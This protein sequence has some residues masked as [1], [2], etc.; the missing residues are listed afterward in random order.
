MTLP[1]AFDLNAR[2][3]L[4]GVREQGVEQ[5]MTA[6]L[7]FFVKGLR[8]SEILHGGIPVLVWIERSAPGGRCRSRH[9]RK[10]VREKLARGLAVHFA[11]LAHDVQLIAASHAA[12]EYDL[13]SIG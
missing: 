4:G 5:R 6:L 7:N 9:G 10:S 11:V 12:H 13:L 1:G 3:Q 2:A 8:M